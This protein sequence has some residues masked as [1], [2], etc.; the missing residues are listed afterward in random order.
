MFVSMDSSRGPNRYSDS[1]GEPPKV[2]YSDEWGVPSVTPT[3]TATPE[4]ELEPTLER[5]PEPKPLRI[6]LIAAGVVT[7]LALVGGGVWYT[8][9]NTDGARQSTGTAGTPAEQSSAIQTEADTGARFVTFEDELGAEKTRFLPPTHLGLPEDLWVTPQL[10]R[11]QPHQSVAGRVNDAT[12]PKLTAPTT[13]RYKNPTNPTEGDPSEDRPIGIATK[14]VTEMYNVCIQKGTSYSKNLVDRY[15]EGLTPSL[16]DALQRRHNAE[17]PNSHSEK[18]KRLAGAGGSSCRYGLQAEV[19]PY[20][21]EIESPN[22]MAYKF[23]VQLLMDADDNGS[24]NRFLEGPRFKT[25]VITEFE[26]EK[27]LVSR[28]ELIDGSKLP[29]Y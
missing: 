27:W 29:I 19:E 26:D 3:G 16:K 12:L 9:N 18:W 10:A 1:W 7:A 23:E 28:I 11:V 13:A 22:T 8:T 24:V 25:E 6:G 15:A 14:A 5:E 20:E 17:G 2:V 21:T 4:P